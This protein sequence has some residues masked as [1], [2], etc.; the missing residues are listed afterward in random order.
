[1]HPF[2]WLAARRAVA[3]RGRVGECLSAGD[4]TAYV[5]HL[6]SKRQLGNGSGQGKRV[7]LHIHACAVC[8]GLGESLE[9]QYFPGSAPKPPKPTAKTLPKRGVVRSRR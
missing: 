7:F 4:L 2:V 3:A 9:Q 1:M 5:L 8:R 6:A